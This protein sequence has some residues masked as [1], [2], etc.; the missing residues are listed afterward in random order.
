MLTSLLFSTSATT[1]V[2]AIKNEAMSTYRKH[3]QERGQFDL[4]DRVYHVARGKSPLS[5]GKTALVKAM[6]SH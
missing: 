2:K 1:V 6:L 3:K 5:E 4:Q